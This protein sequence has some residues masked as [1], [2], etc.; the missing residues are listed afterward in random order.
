M[1]DYIER[2]NLLNNSFQFGKELQISDKALVVKHY[3]F[4]SEKI[5]LKRKFP[6][7]KSDNKI[8]E[9]FSFQY[10]VFTPINSTQEDKAVVL[11]HGLN[12]RHW[13]KYLTWAEYIASNLQIPVILFPI[14]YHINRAPTAWADPRKMSDVFKLR[15]ESYAND[16]SLSYANIALSERID[17]EPIR[18]YLSGRQTLMDMTQ[19]FETIKSGKHP[20]FKQ[21]TDINIFAYSIGAFLAQIALLANY[22]KMFSSTRLF[23]FCGGSILN[24]MY[25]ESR[26]ILDKAS[27]VKM[28][29]YYLN[30]F[31]NEKSFSC[32][33]DDI[34]DAFRS[35]IACD[36]FREERENLFSKLKNRIQAISLTKDIV[37]PY[38]G[39][40]QAL[41]KDN[42]NDIVK[43]QDFSFSYTHE[44]PFPVHI[45]DK[46]AL[47]SAFE[48]VFSKATSFLSQI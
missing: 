9:N 32:K 22:R 39:V 37:V 5:K 7:L 13:N 12:E 29:E 10:P 33:K 31:A 3:D 27:F 20:L 8:V 24:S 42:A 11:L 28:K 2:Y 38:K 43:L 48:S 19:L 35:M 14:A 46:T 1:I 21:G 45:E 40:V 44:N 16:R 30:D 15:K 34:F 4:E 26:S 47:N 18:F 25:G 36:A 6:F 41:G 23:M 17:K